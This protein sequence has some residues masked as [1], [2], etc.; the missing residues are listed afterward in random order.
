MYTC[1]FSGLPCDGDLNEEVRALIIRPHAPSSKV[2][3]SPFDLYAP[4]SPLFKATI[5]DFGHLSMKPDQQQIGNLALKQLGYQIEDDEEL[6]VSDMPGDTVL[7]IIRENVF[8]VLG[9][10]IWDDDVTVAAHVE[11]F[12]QAIEHAI[13]KHSSFNVSNITDEETRTAL[14]EVRR[15]LAMDKM[16]NWMGIFTDAQSRKVFDEPIAAAIDNGDYELAKSLG[17][18]LTE[19]VTIFLAMKSMRR[20][21]MPTATIGPQF[22]ETRN[23]LLMAEFTKTSVASY[24]KI[25]NEMID[26]LTED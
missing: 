10:L 20:A 5:G 23:D 12:T 14:K 7:W 22:W 25:Q 1:G 4:V 16:S 26:E 18:Q 13:K 2:I 3:L 19:I 15:I 6:S 21:L 8:Q 17:V 11:T 24:L 9:E